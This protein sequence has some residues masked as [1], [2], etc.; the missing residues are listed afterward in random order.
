MANYKGLGRLLIAVTFFTC[1]FFVNI[2]QL[3]LI[4]LVRPFDKRLSRSIMYYLTYSFYSIL[5]CVAEWYAGSKLHVF[6]DPEDEKHFLGKEHALLLMN[7]TYEI[8]WLTAWMI[9][10][11][12]HSL[13]NAKAYAKKMLR[14]VPILG[15]VWWM[16]E[17]IFLD[18]NFDKDKIVIK[19]QLT[20]VF[21]YPDPVWLLLNAEGTRFTPAK[22]ELS[23]KFAQERGL[24]VLKHHLIPRTKGFITSLPTMRGICPGIHDINLAFKRTAETKPTMLSQL[25]G[26][27]V[28]PYMYIRRIPLSVVPEGEKEAAQWMQDF[29]VEKDKLI[30]SFHETGD[31]F[32][33]SGVK[34]VPEKIYKPRL[35]SLLNF[36]GWASFSTLLILYYMVTSLIAG[37]WIGFFTVFSILAGFY[38]LMEHAVNASKISK[39]SAYGTAAKK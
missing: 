4:V 6:I 15:W 11:K 32:K 12:L 29:Y 27:A 1:G 20:E 9:S 33:T 38:G 26:E 30:D 16:A 14:Y 22:H 5:V 2:A 35:S 10:D 13:G 18:R 25:N 24:P 34:A 7:H 23:V 8:D 3:L 39:A 19:N 21:S 31:F 36:I 28:E 37:N 17:F